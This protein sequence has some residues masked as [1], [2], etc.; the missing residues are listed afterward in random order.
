MVII[1]GDC[2]AELGHMGEKREAADLGLRFKKLERVLD[3][4]KGREFLLNIYYVPN[5]ILTANFH[6]VR[7]E[8]IT[9]IFISQFAIQKN[10]GSKRLNDM[11]RVAQVLKGRARP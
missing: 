1:A 3:V 6:L 5:T 4:R 2:G 11:P 8:D 9:I 7:K 10:Q